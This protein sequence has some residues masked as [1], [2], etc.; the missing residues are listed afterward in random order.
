MMK[1]LS[2]AKVNLHLRVLRKREDCYHDL[3]T[4]M[5][6]ISLY[7]ELEFIP[8]GRGIDLQCPGA[9]LPENEDNI[10]VRAAKKIFSF[11]GFSSGVSITL[12]KTIPIAAGLGGG[13]SNAAMTLLALNKLF[14]FNYSEEELRK[15]GA[16]LGADVPFFLF[17]GPAWAFGIGDRLEAA[18]D[19]PSLWFVLVNPGFE[20]STKVIYQ[21]L[22]L[23]LTNQIIHYS[24]PRFLTREDLVAGLHNDL[25]SVT[26]KMHPSLQEIKE[27]L[28]SNGAE[29]ALMSGS[30]PTVFGIFDSKD[31]ALEAINVLE[32]STSWS[33]FLCRS[34]D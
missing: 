5:Q 7:D 27:Q 11:A 29:G 25:E 8:S 15:L 10:I 28:L 9:S 31:K 3:A 18:P 16:T 34:I 12:H 22:N 32:K 26:L 6:K 4:L 24:I 2:P 13:S 33:V 23:G 1:I 20:V 21:N 30:G 19:V 17:P 14:G